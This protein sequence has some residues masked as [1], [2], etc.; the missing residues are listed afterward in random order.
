MSMTW[1]SA[2]ASVHHQHGV[3]FCIVLDLNLSSSLLL[4]SVHVELE[5]HK[6]IKA[7]SQSLSIGWF[8]G[9]LLT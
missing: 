6:A 8:K 4:T 3:H 2:T 1:A 5:M 7:A 9:W